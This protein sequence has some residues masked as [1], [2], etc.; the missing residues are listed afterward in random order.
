LF[1]LALAIWA[2]APIVGQVGAAR[3]A[4]LALA[5]FFICFASVGSSPADAQP[6]LPGHDDD[7]ERACPMC[8]ASCGGVAPI[9]ARPGQVGVAPVQRVALAWTVAD[10]ALPTPRRD[11]SR[12]ARAPPASS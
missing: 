5:R 11:F 4:D 12:L 8:Q 6:G 3:A 1:G 9:A 7:R 10:R 2:I